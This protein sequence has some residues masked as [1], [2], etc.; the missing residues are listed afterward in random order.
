MEE[1]AEP[2]DDPGAKRKEPNIDI[3]N[4]VISTKLKM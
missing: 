4:L 2:I 1:A 3:L